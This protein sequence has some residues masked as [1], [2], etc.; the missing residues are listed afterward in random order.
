MPTQ[1]RLPW[2]AT[3]LSD[4][5]LQAQLRQVSIATGKHVTVL[6]REAALAMV[7]TLRD[8]MDDPGSLRRIT[9]T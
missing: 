7:A 5:E 1:K 9:S 8:R 3:R 4:P 2:P 6:L